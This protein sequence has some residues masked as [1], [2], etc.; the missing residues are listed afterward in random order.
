MGEDQVIVIGAGPAGV[1]SAVALKDVGLRP[2]VVDRADQVASS[3]RRRY[4]RLRL[5]SGRPFSRLPDRPYPKGTPMFPSRDQVIEYV[6]RHAR[7]DGIELRLG[8]LVERI[9]RDDDGGWLVRTAK[10]DLRTTQ[11]IVATGFENDPF[12]PDWP[13]RERFEGRLLHSGD[14]TNPGSF[15]DKDVLVVGCGSSGM[16]IAHDLAEGGAAKV[17]MAVRTP[18]NIQLRQGPAGLPGDAIAIPLLHLPVA[19]ADRFA[20]FGRKLD[21]GDLTGY[22]LPIP[23]EGVFA[24]MSRLGVSPAIVDKEVIGA[25]KAGRIEVVRG[26]ES[27]DADGVSLSDG[28]RVEPDAVICATGYR[29][30]LEPLLDHLGVLDGRGLP[31][32]VGAEPAAAGLRFIGYVPRPAMIGQSSRDAKRAAQAIAGELRNSTPARGRE[33]ELAGTQS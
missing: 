5:N 3:W 20:N 26:V 33:T 22:G 6:D 1:A 17:W 18:P 29:R 28:A 4:D 19:F 7:E 27:F 2:L 32:A 16:E 15:Q 8:T 10:G 11:L 30:G 23:E 24:R 14:Y 12:V 9:E 13:G 25:I 31:R 21:M